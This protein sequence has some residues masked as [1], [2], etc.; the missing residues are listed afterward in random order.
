VFR[1]QIV[2]LFLD[3]NHSGVD[4]RFFAL[5]FCSCKTKLK[6]IEN[7]GQSLKQRTIGVFDRLFLFSRRALFIILKISLTAQCQVAETVEIG[8]QACHWI[9]G[10]S[11]LNVGRGWSIG[12]MHLSCR[13]R[14]FRFFVLFSDRNLFHVF[15]MT[16]KVMSSFCG[17][18]PVK[19]RTSWMI[20]FT[21]ACAP[22]FALAR[23]VWITRSRP[24]SSPSALSVSVTPSV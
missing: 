22:S 21:I 8:L 19:S 7:C 2:E 10:I 9:F 17:S 16:I 13:S 20:F 12:W 11:L 5:G 1:K 3:E 14:P 15:R 4:R 24:N 6:I 18:E 23:T